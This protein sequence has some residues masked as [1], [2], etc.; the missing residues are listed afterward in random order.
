[1]CAVNFGQCLDAIRRGEHG[2]SGG[3]DNNGRP[4]SPI[5]N[6]TAITYELC[7][8]VCGGGS[9]PFQWSVFSQQF[10][11]WLL[12]WLAL[13]SQ[14]PFGSNDKLDNFVAMLLTVGSPALA[15]YS[16]VLT[17]LNGRWIARR[18][19]SFTYP[20][21]RQAVRILSSLQQAPI[22][23][24]TANSLLASLVILPQN[25]DW[26]NELVVWLDYTHTWSISAVTSISWVVIAYIFTVVDSFT[27]DFTTGFNT[28]GQGVG[29]LWVW[30]LPIVIGWL[31]ISPKCD[32]TR[33][34]QAVKRANAIAFVA[35]LTNEPAPAHTLSRE[36]A[37]SLAQG[38]E[39]P[40]RHD[41]SCTVPIYNYARFLPW[42]QTVEEVANVFHAAS[43][44]VDLNQ[45]VNPSVDWLKE[46]RSIMGPR[47]ENRI[48]T[49]AEVEAYCVPMGEPPSNKSGWG[50]SVFSRMALASVIAL[51]LQWGTTG[52]ALVVNWFTPTTGNSFPSFPKL[53]T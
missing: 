52:A 28:N 2:E 12:P 10:S 8:K 23:I 18:F 3:T 35:S 26:W 22:R 46:D 34:F 42:V 13:I 31:Q 6:A 45:S 49:I 29:S 16:L 7:T 15:A 20:N 30:L 41:E 25:D 5:S 51:A 17:V 36:R 37:I 9:E 47:P 21:T 32:A 50:P 4:V 43:N 1:M 44:R 19:S 11:S 40:V 24:A 38:V 39:D 53:S 48:G 27:G 14:L 33:V